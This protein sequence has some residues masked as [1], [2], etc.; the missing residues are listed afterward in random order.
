[1]CLVGIHYRQCNECHRHFR[2]V[3]ESADDDGLFGYPQ[4]LRTAENIEKIYAMT[5]EGSIDALVEWKDLPVNPSDP[6]EHRRVKKFSFRSRCRCFLWLG[7]YHFLQDAR[8][9]QSKSELPLRGSPSLGEYGCH[10][11][12]VP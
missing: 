10:N 3:R 4:T 8:V 1:M 11:P 9:V 2:E 5:V 7:E 12:E 6:Q